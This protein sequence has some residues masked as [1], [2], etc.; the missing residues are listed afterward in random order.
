MRSLS[1]WSMRKRRTSSS[2]SDDF[3]AP[4]V[5]V[6]PS[7]GTA[8][9]VRGLLELH[10]RVVAEH[11][12]LEQRDRA[13][14]GARGSAR[15]VVDRGYPLGRE[16]DVARVDHLADHALQAEG[17]AVVGREHPGDAARLEQIDLFANDHPAPAGEH[18]HVTQT[19]LAQA[20]DEIRE[21]LDMTALVGA[22][23]HAVH[24]LLERGVHDVVDRAVVA[25]VHHL[26]ALRLEHAPDDV[27]GGVVAVEEARRGHEAAGRRRT[28]FHRQFHLT[29]DS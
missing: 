1:S 13:G 18:A 10:A 4:P 14:Q 23:R 19:D 21:V 26:R 9:R 17:T 5:P 11:A 7:T 24:V 2:V 8:R 22:H 12:A 29:H 6:I 15:Q 28:R 20:L 27:D 16:V 3:P 25:E